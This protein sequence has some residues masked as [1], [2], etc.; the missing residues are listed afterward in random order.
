[1]SNGRRDFQGVKRWEARV[2]EGGGNGRRR[3]R[4]RRR[5]GLKR[6]TVTM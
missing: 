5:G 4:R 6:I 3:R 1:M 2:E